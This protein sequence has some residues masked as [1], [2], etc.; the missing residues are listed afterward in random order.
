MKKYSLTDRFLLKFLDPDELMDDYIEGNNKPFDRFT[1]FKK[2]SVK[3]KER[4]MQL[5]REL[6]QISLSNEKKLK[7]DLIRKRRNKL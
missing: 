1:K 3:E 4:V 2:G 7:I 6:N 5:I